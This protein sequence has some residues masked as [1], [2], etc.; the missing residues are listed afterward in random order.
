M[1]GWRKYW[2]GTCLATVL[3]QGYMDFSGYAPGTC[4]DQRA[5]AAQQQGQQNLQPCSEAQTTQSIR[6]R[7]YHRSY[8]GK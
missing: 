7:R 4:T 1:D 6:S 3:G 8:G 5:A 2:L